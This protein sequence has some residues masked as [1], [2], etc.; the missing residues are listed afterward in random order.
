MFLIVFN[1]G[2]TIMYLLKIYSGVVQC[3]RNSGRQSCDYKIP[4]K[5][6]HTDYI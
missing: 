2:K 5:I 4:H 1:W 3:L 6:C